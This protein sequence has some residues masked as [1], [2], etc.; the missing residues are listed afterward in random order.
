MGWNIRS[1]T[2]GP[3]DCGEKVMKDLLEGQIVLITGGGRG[4]GRAIALHCAAEG[5]KV[6]ITWLSREDDARAVVDEIIGKNGK[7]LALHADV[8]S[9]EDTKRVISE[10]KQLYGR[11]DILVNN[12]GIMK[13]N[14]LLMTK[15]DEFDS[16]IA[17]NCKGPFLYSRAAA[18]LMVKQKSGRIINISSIVGVQGSRGQSVYSATKAFLIGFTKS[19]SKELGPLGITVNAVAPGF[20]ETD[21]IKEV[22][23]DIRDDLIAHIPLGRIGAPDDIAKTVVFLASDLG[24]YIN[25]QVLGVDGG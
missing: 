4:I 11:L 23:T 8:R 9:E 16:L 21:L 20:I 22:K 17:T 3:V 6:I 24:G 15:T 2:D 1:R 10:V 7:A 25:G 5:A 18:K 12:A 14:L 19:L 13:N